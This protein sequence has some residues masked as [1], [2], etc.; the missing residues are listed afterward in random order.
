MKAPC[1][2]SDDLVATGRKYGSVNRLWA[3][4]GNRDAGLLCV[5]KPFT[6]VGIG[7]CRILLA[8]VH[9][10]LPARGVALWPDRSD[11]G[12]R[13]RPAMVAAIEMDSVRQTVRHEPVAGDLDA[14][15]RTAAAG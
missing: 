13:C 12:P 4:R 2:R 5:G 1:R 8:R 7:L 11:L 9:L 15:Y 3:V 14:M 6:P 10:W